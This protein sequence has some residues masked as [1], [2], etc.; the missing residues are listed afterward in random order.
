[1]PSR[2]WP[3]REALE[4]WNWHGNMHYAS[5]PHACHP[6]GRIFFRS[7]SCVQCR[8][9]KAQFQAG[10]LQRQ[11]EGRRVEH[12]CRACSLARDRRQ[13]YLLRE[14]KTCTNIVILRTRA[15]AFTKA[16]L[17]AKHFTFTPKKTNDT[18]LVCVLA[19]GSQ[20]LDDP[21]HSNSRI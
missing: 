3:S 10:D 4:R 15:R 13:H 7:T 1:M 20:D 8:C 17:R 5:G 6:M 11:R 2:Q 16:T 9:W 12:W 19:A 18:N 14:H 21:S